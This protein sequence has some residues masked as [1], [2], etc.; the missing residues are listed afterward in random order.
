M[1]TYQNFLP[2]VAAAMNGKHVLATDQLMVALCD[3]ADTP[4]ASY[5][6]L[7]DLTEIDYA[8][9]STREITTT[10]AAQLAGLF[11]LIVEDLTLT[12]SGAVASFKHV[13]VYNDSATDKDLI[14]F[15]TLDSIVTLTNNGDNIVLDFNQTDGVFKG[16]F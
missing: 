1:P 2:F 8:N 15:Y 4:L 10:S 12:A 6:K 7:T 11:K 13:V 5:S 16:G 14:C 3:A 9:L